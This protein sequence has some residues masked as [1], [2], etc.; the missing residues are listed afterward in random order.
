MVNPGIPTARSTPCRP[1]N[2]MRV[3]LLRVLSARPICSYLCPICSYLLRPLPRRRVS[4]ARPLGCL[5][6]QHEGHLLGLALGEGELPARLF[7][8]VGRDRDGHLLVG[9][10]VGCP[11]AAV[12]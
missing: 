6:L 5:R 12:I 10:H 4:S 7:E 9:Q 1:A 3:Y 2:A 11:V 8:A